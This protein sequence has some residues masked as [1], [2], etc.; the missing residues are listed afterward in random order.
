MSSPV[1]ELFRLADPFMSHPERA[2]MVAVI[3]LLVYFAVLKAKG[4][5]V[6]TLLGVCS[7]WVAFAIWETFATALRW[8]IRVDMLLIWPV[9]LLSAAIA[10]G[11]VVLALFSTRFGKR[12]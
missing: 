8:D 9:L 2:A 3:L 12:P 7:I 6:F 11:A 1:Q 4:V 10:L 5:K